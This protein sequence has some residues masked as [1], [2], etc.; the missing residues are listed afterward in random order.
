MEWV[1]VYTRYHPSSQDRWF[2]G[3]GIPKKK[4]YVFLFDWYHSFKESHFSLEKVLSISRR[5]YLLDSFCIDKIRRPYYFQKGWAH[6]QVRMHNLE[7][8]ICSKCSLQHTLGSFRTDAACLQVKY[9]AFPTCRIT[10]KNMHCSLEINLTD[11]SN[12]SR[13]QSL[14]ESNFSLEDA[15][16]IS[17]RSSNGGNHFLFNKPLIISSKQL[18]AY[19]L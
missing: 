14:K 10:L 12:L 17:Q 3:Y 1:W 11:K 8:I 4:T 18:S 7:E 2:K 9:Y 5:W 16:F 19:W 15:L 6:T 13:W